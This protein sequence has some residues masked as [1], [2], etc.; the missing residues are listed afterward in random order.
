MSAISSSA[1]LMRASFQEPTVAR[2]RMAAERA[3]QV[4]DNLQLQARDAWKQAARAESDARGLDGRATQAQNSAGRAQ[5]RLVSFAAGVAETPAVTAAPDV[6][7][8][9]S[10]TPGGAPPPLVASVNNLGQRVGTV[11]NVTV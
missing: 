9:P 5:A 11:L 10:S 1:N 8:A 4:A 3:Q 6:T 2:L 7:P